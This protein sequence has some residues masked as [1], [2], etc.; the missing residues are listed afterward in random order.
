VG[1]AIDTA[2]T[3][4]RLGVSLLR[5]V[6]V[7]AGVRLLGVS[8]SNLAHG[9]ARQLTLDLAVPPGTGEGRAGPDPAALQGA[10]VAIDR[11]RARFGD[12]A[13]G[14]AVLLDVDGL[15]V[16]RQGDTQW[17]PG[18]QDQQQGRDGPDTR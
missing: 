3:I 8:V 9:S 11:V 12:Q 14:P 6:D 7:S 10:A 5:Q 15:R 16:K 17:G 18:G 13:V 1:D 2:P 4:A